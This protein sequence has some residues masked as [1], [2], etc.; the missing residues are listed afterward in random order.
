M[1][2]KQLGW[3]RR[4]AEGRPFLNYLIPHPGTIVTMS[5]ILVLLFWAQ[6]V[7]A[8]P[9]PRPHTAPLSTNT[10]IPYQGRLTDSAGRTLTGTY[11]MVFRLYD[12]S[13][14]GT[15]L[16]DESWTNA[17]GVQVSDGMFSVMLG[18]HVPL[19]QSLFGSNQALFLGIQVGS[20]PEMLPRVQLGSVPYALAIPDSS[21]TTQKIA[22]GAVSA[23]KLAQGLSGVPR[24]TIVMWSGA[25]RDIPS[26]WQ[27]CDG[28]NGTPN[29]LDRFVLAVAA[30]QDPGESGGSHFK[31]LSA[32]NL[33]AH[34]HTFTTSNDG[35]HSHYS[36]IEN[37][38]GF[39]SGSSK[40][41]ADDTGGNGLGTT[42]N[43]SHS[44][45]GTTN[46]TGSG[47]AI[48]IRP[49]YYRLAFIMKNN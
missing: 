37:D 47:T 13:S 38:D 27:L 43:G 42:S 14:G 45:S 29:L 9:L 10:T 5:L 18:S 26:G 11:D 44:H 1:N 15:S 23:E 7:G 46:A 48:D 22:N 20:D 24:G 36:H 17:G 33:P 31:T 8:L 16:W 25:L 30:G 4:S 32:A 41:G 21:V 3:S 6:S 19:A 34:Q 40:S 2:L 35:S 39:S 49:A 28:T 12:T